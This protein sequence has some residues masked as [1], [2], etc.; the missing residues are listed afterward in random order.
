MAEKLS[1]L[2]IRGNPLEGPQQRSTEEIPLRKRKTVGKALTKPSA[3]GLRNPSGNP[4]ESLRKHKLEWRCLTCGFGSPPDGRSYM[5]AIKHECL[6]RGHCV[7]LWG[8]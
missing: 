6:G 8:V 3:E 2:T 7:N 5:K 4:Q 1:P